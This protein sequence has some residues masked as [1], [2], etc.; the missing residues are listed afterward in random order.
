MNPQIFLLNSIF[1]LFFLLNLILW[2]IIKTISLKFEKYKY[3][4]FF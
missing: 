4:K 2:Q 3:K 1:L